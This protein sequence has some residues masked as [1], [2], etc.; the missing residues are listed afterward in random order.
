MKTLQQIKLGDVQIGQKFSWAEDE[1]PSDIVKYHDPFTRC[2]NE[3]GA[4]YSGNPSDN[5]WVYA[6]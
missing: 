2:A 4:G 3:N 1:Q 5:V 6:E